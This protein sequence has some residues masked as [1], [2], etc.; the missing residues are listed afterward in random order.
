[1][2]KKL[3]LTIIMF[4]VLLGSAFAQE[5]S[6]TGRITSAVDGSPLP[7]VNVVVAGTT[8]GTISD[9]NG[10]YEVQVAI[11][12]RLK[13]QPRVNLAIEGKRADGWYELGK[14]TVTK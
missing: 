12:D 3:F 5:R 8:A 13:H 2:R 4:L 6:V 7:G 11:V 9:M 1:M 14:I 10:K